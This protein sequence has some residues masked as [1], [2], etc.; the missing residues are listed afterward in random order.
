[1]SFTIF[2]IRVSLGDPIIQLLGWNSSKIFREWLSAKLAYSTLSIV[3]HFWM[4]SNFFVVLEHLEPYS[5]LYISDIW[6]CLFIMEGYNLDCILSKA[7]AIALYCFFNLF[8]TLVVWFLLGRW[9]ALLLAIATQYVSNHF[10]YMNTA[11]CWQYFVFQKSAQEPMQI[12]LLSLNFIHETQHKEDTHSKYS[13]WVLCSSVVLPNKPPFYVV[14]LP[15][16]IMYPKFPSVSTKYFFM[17]GFELDFVLS[18][19]Y[20]SMENSYI[21]K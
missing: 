3:H 16:V 5:V 18:Y 8:T 4:V 12:N 14:I 6:R 19:S 20:K 1:M 21:L 9:C 2:F 7:I 13:C 17:L 11:A 15:V 10:L